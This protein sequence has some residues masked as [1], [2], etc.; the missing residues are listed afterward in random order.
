VVVER[1]KVGIEGLP[2]AF[3]GWRIA[4]LSDLHLRPW[5]QPE[6][7]E[8]AVE[9]ANSLRADAI[10]L[11]GDF[12]THEGAGIDELG[13]ILSQLSAPAG[14][15][16]CLGNH[17]YHGRAADRVAAVVR[18]AGVTLLR[19]EGVELAARGDRL[20]I[21]GLESRWRGRPNL[22]AAMK[23][24]A[25]DVRTLLLMHEPDFADTAAKDRRLAL[26]LSGHSHGGQIR[27]PG[28]GAVVTPR[29]AR[30]YVA[31]LYRVGTLQ[32]YVNRGIG[33][34]G[35]PIRIACPPEVTELTLEEAA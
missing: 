15:F 10:M 5:T 1:V 24:C 28:V 29:W 9:I 16:G 14:I 6:E 18:R 4:H 19:N 30:K 2:A 23:G 11:T 20:F 22:A 34:T 26:Q 13:P 12:I 32:V 3:R 33:C 27:L 21:A 17:D 25:R 8:H 31:G 35:L 7:I